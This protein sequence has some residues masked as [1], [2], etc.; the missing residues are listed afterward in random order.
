MEVKRV[1]VQTNGNGYTQVREEE[2]SLGQLFQELAQDAK[3]LV[4]LELDLAKTEMGEKASHVGKDV[5]TMAAGGFVLYAG[6][7]AILAA[8]IIGLASIIP[9]W[10][11]ALLVGALVAGIGYALVQK[12]MSDLKGRNLAPKQTIA[13]LKGNT[14]WA[15]D[16]LRQQSA[17]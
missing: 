13:S 7:L 5:G 15:R 16:E 8:L 3:T 6:F 9:A 17:R 2:P 10:L 14:E 11:A 4:S 1:S 12:G